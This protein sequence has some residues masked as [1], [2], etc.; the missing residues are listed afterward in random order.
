MN[1]LVA[2]LAEPDRDAEL[3]LLV[4]QD[5]IHAYHELVNR[6]WSSVYGKMVRRLGDRHD[7][8]DMAQNVFL[9]IY[10]SRKRYRASARF[11]TWLYHIAQNVAKN[12]I[13]SRKR[14]PTIPVGDFFQN[15]NLEETR[16]LLDW[17]P[18]ERV[19]EQRE[20]Q[21]RV[22]NAISQLE[23]RQRIALEMHCSNHSHREIADS[24]AMSSKAIK[25]LLYRARLQ[26]REELE[27]TSEYSD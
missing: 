15:E 25:S 11:T 26:L 8:E 19:L 24:L 7:A 9:R 1:S 27:N 2:V 18:P 17:S 22:Q 20:T 21:Q 4:Q 12:A 3:M 14:R 6:H 10:R 16:T 23:G 5:D 13:R